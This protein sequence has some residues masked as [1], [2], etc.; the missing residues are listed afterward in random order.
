[1]KTKIILAIVLLLGVGIGSASAQVGDRAFRER[2]RIGAGVRSGQLTR[3]EAYRLGRE[4]RNIHN[5]IRRYRMNDGRIG[6]RERRHI[7]REERMHSRH[8]FRAR[9]NFRHRF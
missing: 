8:I 9:H 6:P 1:M 2:Q 4:Q 5:D 3:P 7:R